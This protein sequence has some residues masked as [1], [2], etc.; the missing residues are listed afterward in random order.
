MGTGPREGDNFEGILQQDG[1]SRG[2]L[3]GAQPI[4]DRATA[5]PMRLPRGSTEPTHRSRQVIENSM[6]MFTTPD[7]IDIDRAKW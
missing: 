4:R 5:R 2:I 6:T 3:G 1:R 7:T